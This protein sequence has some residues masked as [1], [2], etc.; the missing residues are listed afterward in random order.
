[1][2]RIN[3]LNEEIKRIKSLFTEERM[4]GNLVEQEEVLSEG[5]VLK[6][7]SK[8]ED[9]GALQN[10]LKI[11][12][13]DNKF[14]NITKGKVEEFQ[15]NNGL[16]VDGVVGEETLKAIIKKFTNKNE[17]VDLNEDVS[18]D[19]NKLSKTIVNQEV[20]DDNG[21]PLPTSD[22]VKSLDMFKNAPTLDTKNQPEQIKGELESEPVKNKPEEIKINN[23][24][25][26]KSG[27]SEGENEKQDDGSL[28]K[29]RGGTG[30]EAKG[31]GMDQKDFNK[32]RSDIESERGGL[33]VLGMKLDRV[34]II[35]NKAVCRRLLNSMIKLSKNGKT[36][37]E[38]ENYEF[39]DKG[40]NA[41]TGKEYIERIEWCLSNFYNVYEK[42]GWSGKIDTLLQTWKIPMPEKVSNAVQ[43]EVYKII[44]DDNNHI[45]WIKKVKNNKFRFKGK[46]VAPLLDNTKGKAGKFNPKYEKNVYKAINVNPNEYDIVIQK[47]KDQEKD[48]GIFVLSPK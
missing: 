10:L 48:S 13:V 29:K 1:M 42:E 23:Q 18:D 3:N 16:K 7:G 20:L 30:T 35:N 17:S 43:G 34:D 44:S 33:S 12:P 26:K 15:K 2:K 36:R 24:N 45:G 22:W 47:S 40:G 19:I 9:V 6:L 21:N 11:E 14:G 4:F 5:N 32:S 46:G 25:D 28:N 38:L 31:Q 27:D 8:G 39:D 37:R 41:H